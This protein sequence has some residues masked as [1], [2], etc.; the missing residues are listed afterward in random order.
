MHLVKLDRDVTKITDDGTN[1]VIFS[2]ETPVAVFTNQTWYATEYKWSKTTTMH[3]NK[4]VPT[5]ATKVPQGILEA[6][7]K[8]AFLAMKV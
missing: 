6:H 4:F 3:I 5:F 1:A 2:Y 7:A 8:S